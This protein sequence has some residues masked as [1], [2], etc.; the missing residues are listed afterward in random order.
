VVY[1]HLEPCDFIASLAQFFIKA[2]VVI[3]RHHMDYAR[4]NG[5]DKSLSYRLTYS[6]ARDIIVVSSQAKQYMIDEEHVNSSKIHHINLGYNFE[7]YGAAN[8]T[9]ASEIR[10]RYKAD[11]CL[12]TV[13]RLTRSKR[14]TVA[15]DLVEELIARDM[16]VKLLILGKGDLYEELNQYIQKKD[17]TTNVFLIGHVTNVLDYMAAVDF[18]VHPS[19]SE[20]SCITVKE[21]GLVELPV[22]VC[23]DVG[24]FNDVIED[25]SNGFLTDCDNFVADSVQI[26]ADCVRA[27]KCKQIGSNLKTTVQSKYDIRFIAPAYERL[28][29]TKRK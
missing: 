11:I 23:R 25:R 27:D 21:A 24:D 17:L 1:S 9:I 26:I 13:C 4:I 29:H 2:R 7:L 10:S 20:S 14:V 18:L 8:N 19:V 6:L 5:F 12:L 3:C 16:N 22:I 28:F 15:I